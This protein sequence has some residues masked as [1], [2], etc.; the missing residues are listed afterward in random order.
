MELKKLV[1]VLDKHIDQTALAKDL[2][3]MLV[4]PF[5]EKVVA[6]SE[7]TFD[8]IAFAEIKKFIEK[9]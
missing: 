8:D 7:N 2:A 5:L 9:M 6:D 3:I 4:I 1:E